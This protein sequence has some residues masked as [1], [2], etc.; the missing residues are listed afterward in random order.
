M[1]TY[2]NDSVEPTSEIA[3]GT[4]VSYCIGSDSYGGTITGMTASR[5][6]V[7]VRLDGLNGTLMTFTIRK[8]GKYRERGSDVGYLHI[9]EAKTELDPSF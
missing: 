5:R 1:G 2:S 4:P 6:T 7:H 3:L 8:C 9:G